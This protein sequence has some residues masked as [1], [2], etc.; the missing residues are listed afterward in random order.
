[1]RILIPSIY[2]WYNQHH[3]V[4]MGR[5][6]RLILGS[7]PIGG[8][9]IKSRK[10]ARVVTSKYHSLRHELLSL[11][12]ST[13]SE[14]DKKR[15]K[16]EL[17]KEIDD[18][19][20]IDAYQQAS[21]ISTQYFKTSKWIL[22]MIGK[23]TPATDHKLSTLEVGAI[24]TQLLESPR[25]KVR[26]I[27]INSQHPQIEVCDF[28]DIIPSRNFDVVV[29]SMVRLYTVNFIIFYLVLFYEVDLSC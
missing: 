13:L 26:A 29:C 21:V 15:R 18:L 4:I 24:N 17:V 2:A 27:D 20:G 25:L 19:G 28:F 22:K 6:R 16:K 12:N 7:T 9:A 11:P 3:K 8:K 10:V 23:L 5:K 14:T 1:M